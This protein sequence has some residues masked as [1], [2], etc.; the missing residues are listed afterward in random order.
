MKKVKNAGEHRIFQKKS[1][2][3]A[4]QDPHG[5]W[6][7]GNDKARILTDAGLVKVYEKQAAPAGAAPA[8]GQQPAE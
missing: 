8:E 3:Y 1:G 2:R 6:V 5:K 4:V 7:H